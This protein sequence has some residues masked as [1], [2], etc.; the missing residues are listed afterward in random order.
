M[1]KILILTILSVMMIILVAP[2]GA[3]EIEVNTNINNNS[4][5]KLIELNAGISKIFYESS[6]FNIEKLSEI[7][8]F[9]GWNTKDTNIMKEPNKNSEVTEL[10]SFNTYIEYYY[11]NEEW[12]KVRYNEIEGYISTDCIIDFSYDYIEYNLPKNKGFK[13]YLPYNLITNQSSKQYKLQ[14]YAYTGNNGIRQVDNRY[15][16]AIGTAFNT[17][18]GDYVDLVLE[19][20]EIIHCVVSDI[21]ADIHTDKNNIMTISNGCVSEFLVDLSVLDKKVKI[22]GDISLCNDSWNSSVVTLRVYDKNIF[23][24]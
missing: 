5:I 7:I 16:I 21:K 14:N 11:E 1:K 15:C 12:A 17:E 24:N 13:S 23:I 8:S 4:T 10:I 20:G 6:E 19:N 3:N 22:G 2:F 9:N 18:I